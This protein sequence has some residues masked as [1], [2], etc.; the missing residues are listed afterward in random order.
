MDS[1][2]IREPHLIDIVDRE[3]ILDRIPFA[4]VS[5]PLDELPE[6]ELHEL[7]GGQQAQ[8]AKEYE[9]KWSETGLLQTW[10]IINS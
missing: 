9:M 7:H 1:E 5:V 4:E 8:T 2:Y 10:A 3:W 6:P